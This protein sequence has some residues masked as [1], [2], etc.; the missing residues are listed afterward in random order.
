MPDIDDV[1]GAIG[2]TLVGAGIWQLSPAA[3]LIVP[4]VALCLVA[5]WRAG[6]QPFDR[7]GRG[8]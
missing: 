1:I 6:A 7:M 8:G 5:L 4:G 3:G 2:L